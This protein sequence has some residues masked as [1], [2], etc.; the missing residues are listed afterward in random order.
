MSEITP[1]DPDEWHGAVGRKRSRY[2]NRLAREAAQ[3]RANLVRLRIEHPKKG[4]SEILSMAQIAEGTYRKYRSDH[5]EWAA[6]FDNAHTRGA[7]AEEQAETGRALT[8]TE[9]RKLWFGFDTPWFQQKAIDVYT[10]MP[11]GHTVLMLWPPEHGKTTLLEDFVTWKL[12]TDPEYTILCV[13]EGQDLTRQMI[14]RLKLRLEKGGPFPKLIQQ[15]GPFEP[16]TGERRAKTQTWAADR[17]SVYHAQSLDQRSYSFEGVG[18]TSAIAG[19]RCKHLHVDDI[20]SRRSLEHTEKMLG[21]FKQD[22]ISR[23]GPK[24]ITTINGTR[25]GSG[26]FYQRLMEDWDD[27]DMLTVVAF[28]ALVTNNETGELEPLWPYDEPTGAGYTMDDLD[29]MRRKVGEEAWQRNYMQNPMDEQHRTFDEDAINSSLDRFRSVGEFNGEGTV[30]N[31]AEVWIGVDPSLHYACAFSVF[32]VKHDE[33]V[34]LDLVE[35]QDFTKVEQIIGQLEKWCRQYRSNNA[36]VTTIVIESNAF[37]KGLVN[38]ARLLELR[39]KYGV[40][41]V[42]HLTGSNKYDPNIGLPSMAGA[43]H[44][45]QIRIPYAADVATRSRME[46]L[47]NQFRA[48]RPRKRGTE[49]RQDQVMC[50]W[51]PWVRWEQFRSGLDGTHDGQEPP[52]ARREGLPWKPTGIKPTWWGRGAA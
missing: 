52:G 45:G 37:Q 19:R 9:F 42:P 50:V 38:D 25:V 31:N 22:M 27:P 47:L 20:Q 43:M 28:P 4:I 6:E 14:R 3:R 30:P 18:W 2:T 8:F 21:T 13:S 12:C 32:H 17:F 7:I 39:E 26:D 5:P 34:L 29:L 24:G 36:K 41:I 15:Y 46:Q 23:P 1:G 11:P 49:L 44:A 35:R 51:F 40:Q 16:Q 33:M 10:S 48:W